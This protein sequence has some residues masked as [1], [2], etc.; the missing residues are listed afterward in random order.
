MNLSASSAWFTL[1]SLDSKSTA[2]QAVVVQVVGRRQRHSTVLPLPLVAEDNLIRGKEGPHT[3][4]HAYHTHTYTHESMHKSHVCRITCI[5]ICVQAYVRLCDS[6]A[7]IHIQIDISF[8]WGYACFYKISLALGS[9]VCAG[10][11]SRKQSSDH[12][13]MAVAQFYHRQVQNRKL[14]TSAS[15]MNLY[16]TRSF[17]RFPR[18]IVHNRKRTYMRIFRRGLLEIVQKSGRI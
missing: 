5:C 14:G 8:R 17:V 18:A 12:R 16:I 15:T 2:R 11:T 1:I 10:S 3:H 6:Y 7:Y 4:P 9:P 13:P